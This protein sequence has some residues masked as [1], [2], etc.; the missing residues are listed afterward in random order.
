MSSS[1]CGCSTPPGAAFGIDRL[2]TFKAEID[3]AQSHRHL[4]NHEMALGLFTEA[5]AGLERNGGDQRTMVYQ[6]WAIATEMWP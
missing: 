4:G 2:E 1:A 5:L 3:L 6:K